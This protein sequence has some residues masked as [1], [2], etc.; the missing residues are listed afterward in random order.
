MAT[1]KFITVG[2]LK[3][4]YLREAVAEYEKRLSGFCKVENINLKEYK[5]PQD[6]SDAEIAK[7]LSEEAKT[8]LAAIPDRAYKI[9][10]CV[11]G[12]QF[13]SEELADKIDRAFSV[14]SEIVFVIGSSHGLHD[15]VKNVA[16]IKL[17]VSKLTFPH[18][19]MRP[20]L[21]EA[22]YRCM[23]IIKGTKYHK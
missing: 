3:E 9:I 22:V 21:L 10:M 6:P 4:S 19:L 5:V 8:I 2:Q 23:T 20:L 14:S 13:S 17:S 15:S 18:Q 1:I 16:D 12:K 11:E 7:A